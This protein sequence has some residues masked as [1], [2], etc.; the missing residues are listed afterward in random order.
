MDYIMDNMQRLLIEIKGVELEEPEL[1]VY[2]LENGLL[3]TDIYDAN[4]NSNKRGIYLTALHV[5][6][7]LD[8]NP[9]MMST[10]KIDDMTV[11]DFHENLMNRIDQLERKIRKMSN[12]DSNSNIF[13]LYV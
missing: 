7:S 12:S 1:E 4:N 11:S 6:E 2:L 10:I 9:T 3:P 13:M 8:N 5:L